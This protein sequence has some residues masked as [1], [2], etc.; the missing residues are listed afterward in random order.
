MLGEREIET[1]RERKKSQSTKKHQDAESLFNLRQQK[2]LWGRRLRTI[3]EG[4]EE[5]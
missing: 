3:P 4:A 5:D 2:D 1:E